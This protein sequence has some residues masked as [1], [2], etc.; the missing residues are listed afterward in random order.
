LV[1]P[2]LIGFRILEPMFQK[3]EEDMT[4]SEILA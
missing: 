3:K 2:K 1:K 4:S